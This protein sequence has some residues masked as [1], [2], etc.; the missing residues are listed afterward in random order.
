MDVFN[1]ITQPLRAAF[2][3]ISG[4]SGVIYTVVAL[5]CVFLCILTTIN[6]GPTGLMTTGPLAIGAL[7]LRKL[8]QMQKGSN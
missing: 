5:I 8:D 4:F 7:I 6:F 2:N 1:L 3:I